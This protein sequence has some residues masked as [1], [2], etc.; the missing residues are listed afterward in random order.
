MHAHTQRDCVI[1]P[2][3][4][5]FLSLLSFDVCLLACGLWVVCVYSV[6]AVQMHKRTSAHITYIY[7]GQPRKYCFAVAVANGHRQRHV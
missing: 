6:A 5:F 3:V 2:Y 4:S 7:V 1:Q